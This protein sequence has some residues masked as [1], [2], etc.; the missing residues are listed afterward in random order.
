MSKTTKE[1]VYPIKIMLEGN[2]QYVIYC[3]LQEDI[4]S[5]KEKWIAFIEGRGVFRL[6][7]LVC[8]THYGTHEM[9]YYLSID[10]VVSIG[11]YVEDE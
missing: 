3:M 4:D 9:D 1:V 2:T 10:K 5:L 8:Y 11:F 7:K 6:T